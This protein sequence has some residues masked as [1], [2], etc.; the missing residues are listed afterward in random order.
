MEDIL[1][2]ASNHVRYEMDMLLATGSLLG[3]DVEPSA[4]RFALIEA[5]LVHARN[6]IVFFSQ[7]RPKEPK[8]PDDVWASDYVSQWRSSSG[9]TEAK[10]LSTLYKERIDQTVAHLTSKRVEQA[11]KDWDVGQIAN[12]LRAIWESF[13]GLLPPS[14]TLPELSEALAL[15]T[16]QIEAVQHTSSNVEVTLTPGTAG[17]VTWVDDK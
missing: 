13:I 17:N 10:M 5:F 3:K 12:D 16:V 11:L 6:L 14:P 9:Q 1:G 2:S 7:D 4:V 8:H 15:V